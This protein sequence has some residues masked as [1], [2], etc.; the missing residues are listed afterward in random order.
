MSWDQTWRLRAKRLKAS[1]LQ[2]RAEAVARD[3]AG[4]TVE[5]ETEADD[6]ITIFFSVPTAEPDD[7]PA[8]LEVSIYAMG[9]GTHIVS[10]EGDAADNHDYWD[11]AAQLAEDLA[12]ALGAQPLEL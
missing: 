7:P 3:Y 1:E 2:P 6:C 10:L 8:T 11:D 4:V 5:V 12:A 9:D